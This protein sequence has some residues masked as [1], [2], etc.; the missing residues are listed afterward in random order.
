V[1]V[2]GIVA[3]A[4]TVTETWTLEERDIIHIGGHV[5]QRMHLLTLFTTQLTPEPAESNEK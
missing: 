2:G 1:P 3:A 5:T 4:A